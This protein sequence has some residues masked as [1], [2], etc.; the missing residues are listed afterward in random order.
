LSAGAQ[1]NSVQD[2]ETQWLGRAQSGDADAFSQLVEA[3]QTAVY[4]LCYRML[5]DPYEAE[6]AAQET[7]LRAYRFI[8]KYD[9]SR[10]FSTWLLSIAAHYCIDQIRKRRAV[11][12]PIEELPYQEIQDPNPNPEVL[13][14]RNE[15]G[16]QVQ[17]LLDTLNPVD[18][19]S[20]VMYYWYDFSY[21]EIAQALGLTTSAV[22]SR[23][24]RS[25]RELALAWPGYSKQEKNTERK[26]Y[27]SPAF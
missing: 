19:A 23:L 25:R 4:N 26:R 24:H 7:F 1:E 15:E 13:A 8:T 21:E 12:L 2:V 18:R 3:Y 22:K 5:G 27:E 20:I 14:S 11:I 17:S 16:R 10:S 9:R 6:D